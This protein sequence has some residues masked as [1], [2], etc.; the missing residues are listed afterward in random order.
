ME[1][2]FE[3]DDIVATKWLMIGVIIGRHF[4]TKKYEVKLGR[5]VRYFD[6]QELILVCAA[7]NRK[8]K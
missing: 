5:D 6:K 3:L 1:R 2:E 7:E 8:D 4:V